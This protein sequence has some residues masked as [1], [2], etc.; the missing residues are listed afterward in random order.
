VAVSDLSQ[1]LIDAAAEADWQAHH[2]AV[3]TAIDQKG[4]QD[5]RKRRVSRARSRAVVIA[6]LE[7]LAAAEN[8][9]ACFHP[10][11]LRGLAS[12]VRGVGEK[13]TDQ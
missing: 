4:S 6:V 13:G 1:S 8:E 3:L 7:T 10:V 11:R 9:Y 5:E 2:A 12:E